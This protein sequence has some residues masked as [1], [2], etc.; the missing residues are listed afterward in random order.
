MTPVS[1][2]VTC[3]IALYNRNLFTMDLH[4]PRLTVGRM[5]FD[6]N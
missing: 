3:D 6:D 2:L 5:Y 4:E 1:M